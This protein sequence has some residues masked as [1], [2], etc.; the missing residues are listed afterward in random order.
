MPRLASLSRKRAGLL[1]TGALL[2][3]LGAVAGLVPHPRGAPVG[4]LLDPAGGI[5]AVAAQ[6]DGGRHGLGGTP[7]RRAWV[8]AAGAGG[9]AWAALLGWR[10]AVSPLVRL[11]HLLA[12]M[13]HLPPYVLLLATVLSGTMLATGGA[14]LGQGL[15]GVRGPHV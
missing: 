7:H 3:A 6:D 5:W 15:R 4:R 11:D 10:A 2:L 13:L 14:M 1:V 8:L 9:L 12:A